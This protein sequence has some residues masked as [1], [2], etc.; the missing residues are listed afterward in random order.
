MTEENAVKSEGIDITYFKLLCDNIILFKRQFNLLSRD[1]PD[2]IVGNFKLSIIN[3]VLQ[4][5]RELV[6]DD[7]FCFVLGEMR[8][9][10]IDYTNS[11]VV[12]CWGNTW[13]Q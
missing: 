7:E 3:K 11:D 8:N 6:Q 1:H 12:L 5:S 4:L 10:D 9:R 13:L 2:T